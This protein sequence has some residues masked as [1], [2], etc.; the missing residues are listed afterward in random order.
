[1]KIG[2]YSSMPLENKANWSGTMYKMYEQILASGHEV[3]WIPQQVL[4]DKETN[5]LNRIQNIFYRIFQ[6]GYNTK[7][8]IYASW[9]LGKKIE[10]LLAGKDYDLLFI[11]TYLNDFACVKTK[12]PIIYL[13][14]ANVA[15]LLNYYPYYSGF[16]WLSKWETKQ[17]EKIMLNKS[18]INI[19]S[20]EWAANCAVNQ[21]KIDQ[22]KVKVLKFGA[23]LEVPD[24]WTFEKKLDGE[25]VFLFLAVDW[26]R[27]RG[28]LAYQSLKRLRDKGFP[29]KMQIIGC[30]PDIQ[31]DWVSI[32]PFLSKNNPEELK[33]I[34]QHLLHAHFLFVPTKADCTPIAFCEAAGYG[35]PIISTDTGGVSAHVEN[36]KTG[37]LLPQNASPEDYENAIESILTNPDKIKAMSIA[38]REK[39]EK[40]LNWEVWK[41]K[42]EEIVS[43]I[44]S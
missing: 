29:V 33:Q 25:I 34:Q 16:G 8:N 13:N 11:P 15:Q 2:F 38:S 10:T 7:V 28:D 4:D 32:I 19:F 41:Y 21:Y 27:K 35:L 22:N 30:N 36:G 37:L 17:V 12:I 44:K 42:Y 40:E 9:M 24:Q 26:V 6:R 5:K 39:Y 18:A 20:S 3:E 1:M 23:N 14:D 31:E 43:T